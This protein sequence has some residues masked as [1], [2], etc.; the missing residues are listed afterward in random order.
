MINFF[1]DILFVVVFNVPFKI[2]LFLLLIIFIGLKKCKIYNYYCCW[3]ALRLIKVRS[4][5]MQKASES[6][7]SGMMSVFLSKDSKLNMALLGARK[8]CAEQLKMP[9]PIECKIANYLYH[10][11]KVIGGNKEALDFIEH[12]YKEFNIKRIKRLPVSGAFHTGLM[13]PAEFDLKDQLDHIV[14]Q[15]PLIK[16]YSNY[17]ANP[18]SHPNKIKLNLVKQ[19]SGPVRW[20]QTLNNLYYNENLPVHEQDDQQSQPD[21]EHSDSGQPARTVNVQTDDRVYPDIYECGPAA[22]TGPILREINYKAYRFYKHI[23]V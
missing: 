5:S 2:F 22:Q 12:N 15:R 18:C 7:P 11:C 9:D 4:D 6:V 21:S 19:V 17:T 16:F 14:I 8:W 1:L 10:G 20:E 23:G 3:T 13:R